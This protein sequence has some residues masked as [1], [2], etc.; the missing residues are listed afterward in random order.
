MNKYDGLPDIDLTVQ[1]TFETSDV[2][3]SSDGESDVPQS[4]DEID[5]ST[6]NTMDATVK[7]ETTTTKPNFLGSIVADLATSG[8]N[9]T[10][11]VD[12][13]LARIAREL[14]ELR[15]QNTTTEQTIT[16]NSLETIVSD[17]K[18]NDYG[19]RLNKLLEAMEQSHNVGDENRSVAEPTSV[20]TARGSVSGSVSRGA[21]PESA[22]LL[23]ESKISKLEHTIGLDLTQNKSVANTVAD[24]SRKINIVHNPEYSIDK[25]SAKIEQINQHYD[26]LIN[27]SK[28]FDIEEVVPPVSQETKIDELYANL[29][30]FE[31]INKTVPMI[32]RRLKSLNTIHHDLGHTVTTVGQIDGVINDIKM[33]LAKWNTSLSTVQKK[34]DAYETDAAANH[35]FVTKKLDELTQRL[36]KV[37]HSK[38]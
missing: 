30:H 37:P 22:I 16:A 11:T 38:T 26:T 34:L 36:G 1:D 14:D 17:L 27:K 2:D 20:G 19:Q 9:G 35:D 5:Y 8:Y 29:V 13:K 12:E 24:L 31:S 32:L 4:T 18:Y 21:V 25:V 23:L 6:V 7:F 3:D 28:L 33:D 15:L 10:E